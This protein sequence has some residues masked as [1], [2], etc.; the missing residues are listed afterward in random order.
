MV[1]PGRIQRSLMRSAQLGLGH[2]QLGPVV[3][4]HGLGRVLGDDASRP[5]AGVVQHPMTSVR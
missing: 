2:G 3:D 1:T 4:A 5:V